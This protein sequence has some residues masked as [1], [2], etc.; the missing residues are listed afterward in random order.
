MQSLIARLGGLFR[1]SRVGVTASVP[2]TRHQSRK[3]SYSNGAYTRYCGNYQNVYVAWQ[4]SC[5]ATQ[6][7][8]ERH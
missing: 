4:Y 8:E 1:N 7:A 2:V 3:L 5:W 6:L